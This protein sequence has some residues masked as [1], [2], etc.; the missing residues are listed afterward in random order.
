MILSSDKNENWDP[1]FSKAPYWNELLIYVQ[2]Y[3]FIKETYAMP[4][5][6]SNLQLYMAKAS[7]ELTPDT[8]LS[9]AYQ[10]WRANEKAQPLG[11]TCCNVRRRL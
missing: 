4:G 3:E 8:K 6:W 5:Y 2:I 9:L 11:C 1:L 10:Y 7:M